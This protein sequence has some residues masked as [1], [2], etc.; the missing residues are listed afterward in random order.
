MTTPPSQAFE[1]DDIQT[2]CDVLFALQSPGEIDLRTLP[3]LLNDSRI[4]E[5][6]K[7]LEVPPKNDTSRCKLKEGTG[8][9]FLFL[10]PHR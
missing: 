7:L 8:T 5:L 10:G 6:K 2:L 3:D 1:D 9:T 4:R